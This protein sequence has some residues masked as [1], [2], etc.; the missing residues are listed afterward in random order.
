M[1]PHQNPLQQR[2]VEFA[3][4]TGTAA[5]GLPRNFVGAEIGRQLARSG[6]SPA[7]NY[8]EAK[9]SVSARDYVFKMHVCLKELRETMVWLKV[10]HGNG[11]RNADYPALIAECNELIAICV[12]CVKKAKARL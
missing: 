8:A 1:P 10:A 6:M 12:T 11:F 9:E 2:L 4:Q 3:V 5:R 7:A